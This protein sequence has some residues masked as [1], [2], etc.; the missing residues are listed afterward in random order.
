MKKLIV[1]KKPFA[2]RDPYIVKHNGKYYRC[3]TEDAASVSVACADTLEGLANAKGKR[4]YIP[5]AG[6]EY[7]K[8]L[9]APELHV[10]DGKCYIYVACDDGKNENHRMYVLENRSSDPTD[11]YTVHG[12]IADKTDKWA[13][14]GT[15]FRI[16][17]KHYFVWSGW[18]GDT[19]GCQNLYIAEMK[20]PF[21]LSSERYLISTPEYDWEKFG[22]SSDL[23]LINEGAFGFCMDGEYYLAY[24]ASG[25][26]C[27][28]YCIAVLKLT[29]KDPLN[30]RCWEKSS[31]PVLSSNDLLQGAGHCSVID[32]DGEKV[33]FFHAWDK[34]ETNIRWDTVFV[35]Q[36]TLRKIGERITI[37]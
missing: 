10:L 33:V 5:E 17:D 9:W 18:E 8:E 7:S 37:E 36:A 34:E 13:I 14:D 12:K 35:W 16:F 24:S 23:P 4:V 15:V 19:N 28:D 27:K 20:N 6:Q 22:A 1:S 25:S 26:W 11:E 21:E 29:G 30:R 2:T 31:A 3:Y 32:E